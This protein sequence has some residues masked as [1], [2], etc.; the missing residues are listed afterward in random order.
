[1]SYS[2]RYFSK[3]F[4]SA[5]L[6]IELFYQALVQSH[7]AGELKPVLSFAALKRADSNAS[8]KRKPSSI[9]ASDASDHD[10]LAPEASPAEADSQVFADEKEQ[11]DSPL[12]DVPDETDRL[13]EN[14]PW[15]R[16][17]AKLVNSFNFYCTHQG[18]CHPNCFRRQMRAAKRIMEATRHVSSFLF[19]P[20]PRVSE[21]E[22]VLSGI[23]E[24][25][26]KKPKKT[27]GWALGGRRRR[28]KL[29]W[30]KKL[31][32]VRPPRKEDLIGITN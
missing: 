22:R 26:G 14:M 15:L 4:T 18:F 29:A 20:F 31:F 12:F 17:V 25:G 13:E 27:Q 8:T 24:A 5:K 9:S 19:L 32:R 23:E 7:P 16:T 2:T 1:M 11:L 6:L 30:D 3:V 28:N 21:R 10:N